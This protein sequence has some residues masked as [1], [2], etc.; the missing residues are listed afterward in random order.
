MRLSQAPGEAA[1]FLQ[2]FGAIAQETHA[3]YAHNA[4]ARGVRTEFCREVAT[5]IYA[6][7]NAYCKKGRYYH[8]FC[9]TL[10][11][12]LP[13]P[14][15]HSPFTAGGRFDH[16]HSVSMAFQRDLKEHI[17][18]S[19]SHSYRSGFEQI[20]RRCM[21]EAES[22]L[23]PHYLAVFNSS[24]ESLKA[25]ADLIASETPIPDSN[26]DVRGGG[27]AVGELDCD[28]QGFCDLSKKAGK[29]R[30]EF[31]LAV[32]ESKPELFRKLRKKSCIS[33]D[34]FT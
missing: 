16:N 28:M 3:D 29:K 13:N 30:D 32:L 9:L 18:L 31:L 21:A 2:I 6:S 24:R 12:D 5:G 23:L 15:L 14:Y 26:E 8:G 4:L 20:V 34:A 7:H 27:W 22:Q 25:L 1:E 19:D 33:S 11:K 10:H 17:T